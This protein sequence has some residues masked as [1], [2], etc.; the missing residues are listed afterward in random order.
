MARTLKISINTVIRTL[1]S[2]RPS[3]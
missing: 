1:K 3:G 2:S